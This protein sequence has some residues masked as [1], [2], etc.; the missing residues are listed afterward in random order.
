MFKN[1]KITDYFGCNFGERTCVY[2][3][4]SIWKD[5]TSHS[6]QL[7]NDYKW[8]IL[9]QQSLEYRVSVLCRSIFSLNIMIETENA[10]FK[11]TDKP[12]FTANNGSDIVYVLLISTLY[13]HDVL[14]SSCGV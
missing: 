2:I 4:V 10:D 11:I 3:F 6:L 9:W 7:S 13:A 14:S 12:Y 5:K 1:K 8:Y